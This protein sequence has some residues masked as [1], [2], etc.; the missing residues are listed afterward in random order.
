M[1]C[2]RVVS[3]NSRL[4]Y[5][6]KIIELIVSICARLSAG[7]LSSCVCVF[8]MKWEALFLKIHQP[9]GDSLVQ[10]LSASI[11]W[12][13]F[14]VPH[15]KLV[16]DLSRKSVQLLCWAKYSQKTEKDSKSTS[17]TSSTHWS[18]VVLKFII[19][20]TTTNSGSGSQPKNYSVLKTILNRKLQ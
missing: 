16:G 20:H 18:L 3:L 8:G 9:I 4:S 7:S 12:K 19:S 1:S 2:Y 5:N 11:W 6:E 13:N 14:K 17:I 10:T 15:Q